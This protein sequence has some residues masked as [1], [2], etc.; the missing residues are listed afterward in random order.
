MKLPY[1]LVRHGPL[2]SFHVIFN[3]DRRL[4]NR[5]IYITSGKTGAYWMGPFDYSNS[6]INDIFDKASE[7]DVPFIGT[8]IGAY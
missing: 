3:T 2:S 4:I 1:V 5:T 8:R 7:I 6:D